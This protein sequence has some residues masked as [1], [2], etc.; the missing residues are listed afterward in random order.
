MLANKKSGFTIV[1]LLIVIVVIG[2][3]AAIVVVAYNGITQQAKVSQANSELSNF[4]R[5]MLA[6]K[7]TTGEL[8]PVGDSWNYNTDPPDCARF[9]AAINALSTAGYTGFDSTDPW[10]NCWGYD[11]N[12]CNTSS[13][14]GATTT[15]KS[16][17]P[18]GA[19]GNS[20]DVSLLVTTKE[21]TGC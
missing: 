14:V 18:D 9:N 15:I 16:V 6:Y 8:P 17:G 21:A 5:A 12:D 3:L 4:K 13:L 2:I 1:E 20:D 7:A 19:N 10:G 11:D